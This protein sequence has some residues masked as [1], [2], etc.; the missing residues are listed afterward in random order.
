M[1]S[2]G[3]ITD[4]N[5]CVTVSCLFFGIV[6]ATL[7]FAEFNIVVWWQ[8]FSNCLSLQERSHFIAPASTPPYQRWG[9]G[10]IPLLLATS[11]IIVWV[12]TVTHASLSNW[13]RLTAHPSIISPLW[14]KPCRAHAGT[15]YMEASVS[16]LVVVSK[17]N[18]NTSVSAKW[19]PGRIAAVRITLEVLLQCLFH[20]Q[21]P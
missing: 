1:D 3:H 8:G 19:E 2:C 4:I 11:R 15:A 16:F 20:L 21:D 5:Q 6:L 7:S 17:Q 9:N 10:I 13:S 18:P 14:I 12:R